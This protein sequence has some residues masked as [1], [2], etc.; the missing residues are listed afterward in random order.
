[1]DGKLISG[2]KIGYDLTRVGASET[3]G[4]N[5]KKQLNAAAWSGT[6]PAPGSTLDLDFENNR[7][8]VRGVGQG[9]VMDAITFTRASN[10][11]YV[12][13]D[14]LLKGAG[15]SVGALGKNLF[16]FP[17]NFEN[18]IWIKSGGLIEA[19]QF[20]APDQT[21]TASLFYPTA[22]NGLIF[23]T[24]PS[25]AI[26]RTASCFIKAAGFTWVAL[27]TNTND[28]ARVFFDLS[29]GVVGAV[30]NLLTNASISAV[31]DGWFRC[32]FT[33]TETLDGGASF[34]I[35]AVNGDAPFS[36][37]PNGTDGVLI[38]GA[39]LEEGTQA[40]E[41][42]PTNINQP[43]FD[44]SSTTQ[45]PRIN[46]LTFTEDLENAAWTKN[47]MTV[48]GN[49]I[50]AP[51]NIS[52]ADLIVPT[53]TTAVH[54]CVS[55]V[56]PR[57]IPGRPAVISV[58]VKDAGARYFGFRVGGAPGRWAF[59]D[60]QNIEDFTLA[61]VSTGFFTNVTVSDVG[62][63][64]FRVVMFAD[65][66]DYGGDGRLTVY[67]LESQPA[68][69][70]SFLESTLSYLGDG[71][72]GIYVWG[73]QSESGDVVTDYVAVGFASPTS[74]PLAANPTMNGILIETARTNR[75]L[76]CR[77]PSSGPGTNMV[78]AS[79][80]SSTWDK[81]GI[82]IGFIGNELIVNGT[83]DTN[84]DGWTAAG[85]TI[86]IISQQLQ[87]AATSSFGEAYQFI[88][89]TPGK[90][91]EARARII[92]GTGRFRVTDGGINNNHLIGNIGFSAPYTWV[93][94][95]RPTT[96]TLAV[97]CTSENTT[98]TIW[99]DITIREISSDETL[100][101]DDTQT[102]S[103]AIAT[104]N[105][106]IITQA[107]VTNSGNHTF[108]VWLRRKSG[109]GSV[110]I[111]CDPTIEWIEQNV[112]TEWNRYSV[113]QNYIGTIINPG[114][115]ISNINDELE[116]WGPQLTP[117]SVLT[118]YQPTDLN[119]VYGWS[120][121]GIIPVKD[122]IGID[123]VP[124][125]ATRLTSTAGGAAII[126]PT[127]LA[128]A[129]RTC[130]V[131]LKRISGTGIVQVTLD[132]STWST[133]DLSDTEW[134]RVVLSGTV[135]NTT[136][137]IKLTTSGDSV[138]MDFA[139]TED[140]AFV[141]S[142]IFTTSA[143]ATRSV[144]IVNILLD[145]NGMFYSPHNETWFCHSSA[146]LGSD[147]NILAAGTTTNLGINILR[148]FTSGVLTSY[149][150]QTLGQLDIGTPLDQT[151]IKTAVRRFY[152]NFTATLDGIN[153]VRTTR[154]TVP[155]NLGATIFLGGTNVTHRRIIYFDKNLSDN[156][157]LVLTS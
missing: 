147:T 106:G 115:R 139:Q 56:I 27:G 74:T 77:D 66:D 151:N 114:I 6:W 46:R 26:N 100:A 92:S 142:P 122:Q 94:F 144:D 119:A 86:S 146:P 73:A 82:D 128:S 81:N 48:S 62:N 138:A 57:N 43:R 12:G 132:G 120:K 64:W 126:Q 103:T 153:I 65:S 123:G 121:A 54:S 23:I 16:T 70:G 17:Q 2:P 60:F 84:T 124:N 156:S 131:Y 72:S 30:G 61:G 145:P 109:T 95:I 134:R 157:L 22:T 39:Q 98:T 148:R 127:T 108:S 28:G 13:E 45:L 37:T 41:Y 18:S 116:V 102:A 89:V 5:R 107:I 32:S 80:I 7:G 40:T 118:D 105:N 149:Y 52:Q 143:A 79:S 154:R 47:S 42:F 36:I 155:Q 150:N 87:V 88:S 4:A 44:W 96:S 33:T 99:D 49:V 104:T 140:G 25:N 97:R 137:G 53:I 85:A 130:S 59:F 31:G 75:V 110:S 129:A 63:G 136:L 11:T 71:I 14:G 76:W 91:Y 50:L 19:N 125:A 93:G 152:S 10:G 38:W 90:I 55:P 21:L 9:G 3:R 133:V 29:N 58:Y 117:G 35:W 24:N 8:W 68:G 112:T 1:M 111:T 51:N 101:P 141:T 67:T 113:T 20:L 15:S 78:R 83:F 135:T 34:A 69:G